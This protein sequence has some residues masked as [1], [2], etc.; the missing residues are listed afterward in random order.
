M[1]M[2]YGTITLAVAVGFLVG[3]LFAQYRGS[4]PEVEPELTCEVV[5]TKIWAV[6]QC[7]KF[8]PGCQM[9]KGPATFSE[10]KQNKDWVAEHCP[11]NG[12]GFQS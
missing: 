10:Y 12:D 4:E 6:Q 5:E 2:D 9:N 1:K 11:E 7:L 8:Q 3:V